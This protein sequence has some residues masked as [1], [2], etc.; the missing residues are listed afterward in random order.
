M[1]KLNRQTEFK[2]TKTMCISVFGSS[3]IAQFILEY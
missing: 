1:I 3:D 2:M